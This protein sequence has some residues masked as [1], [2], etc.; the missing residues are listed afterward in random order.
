MVGISGL[1]GGGARVGI[2]ANLLGVFLILTPPWYTVL[3]G[4]PGLRREFWSC[5][6]PGVGFGAGDS[7]L[8]PRDPERGDVIEAEVEVEAD[9]SPLMHT[10]HPPLGLLAIYPQKE[11]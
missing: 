6:R 9:A 2:G 8:V 1:G 4:V 3:R 10:G 11:A 5:V 7:A